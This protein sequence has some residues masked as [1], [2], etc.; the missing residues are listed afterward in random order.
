MGG[1]MHAERTELRL[2]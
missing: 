1:M 2:S